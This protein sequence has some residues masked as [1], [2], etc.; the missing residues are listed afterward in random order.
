[1]F[2]SG[3]AKLFWCF[4]SSFSPFSRSGWCR[5]GARFSH[6]FQRPISPSFPHTAP[7]GTGDP[8]GRRKRSPRKSRDE[9]GP[10]KCGSFPRRPRASRVAPYS[11][12]AP[13]AVRKTRPRLL[14][15]EIGQTAWRWGESGANRSPCSMGLLPL[16]GRNRSAEKIRWR[17][18]ADRRQGGPFTPIWSS[19]LDGG[20]EALR[21]PKVDDLLGRLQRA[22][23]GPISVAPLPSAAS[24]VVAAT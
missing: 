10:D 7:P 15:V 3:S 1:M 22:L 9:T 11:G 13:E 2:A 14:P 18:R 16:I 21:S 6:R 23:V 17:S 12:K 8:L 24:L 20:R 4:A 5:L 19:T